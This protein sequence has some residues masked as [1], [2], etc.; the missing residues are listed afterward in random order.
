MHRKRRNRLRSG[1]NFIRFIKYTYLV[2]EC[3]I[4]AETYSETLECTGHHNY[5]AVTG[6][7]VDND[8]KT[9]FIC[10]ECGEYLNSNLIYK[11]VGTRTDY[12]GNTR[13]VTYDIRMT[14]ESQAVVQPDGSVTVSAVLNGY[15]PDDITDIKVKRYNDD[16]TYTLL[17]CTVKDGIVTFTTDHFCTFEF[18]IPADCED[19]GR[20][21]DYDKDGICDKCGKAVT[22]ADLFRCSM[23]PKY[24]QMKDIPVIGIIYSVIHFFIHL[25]SMI[26]HIS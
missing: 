18:V 17:P 26:S 1:V 11:L 8:A 6:P 16:S 24:E 21:E 13:S 4:C 2:Y 23:C 9:S 22:K 7:S 19:R 20:H 15:Y 25:A 14:D 5:Y 3:E 12:R 10:S